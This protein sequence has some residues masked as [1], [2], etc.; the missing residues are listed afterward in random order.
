LDLGLTSELCQIV[1]DV[2]FFYLTYLFKV[3]KTQDLPSKIWQTL[4]DDRKVVRKR[5]NID[6]YANSSLK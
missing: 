3:G 2:L 1:G 4:G 5:K 6:F